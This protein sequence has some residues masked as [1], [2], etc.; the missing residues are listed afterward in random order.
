MQ[1]DA[2]KLESI[3]QTERILKQAGLPKMTEKVRASAMQDVRINQDT[4]GKIIHDT[5]PQKLHLPMKR[6]ERMSIQE[7]EKL[8]NGVSLMKQVGG[9]KALQGTKVEELLVIG[10]KKTGEKEVAKIILE[11]TGR[12]KT[13]GASKTKQQ[14][15][16]KEL[17]KQVINTR[18]R[19]QQRCF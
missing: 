8:V 12:K 2:G 6:I 17:E 15:A 3:M 9:E 18:K 19:N 13:K 10:D 7:K 14:S 5:L 4:M 1:Q 11:K 16:Q